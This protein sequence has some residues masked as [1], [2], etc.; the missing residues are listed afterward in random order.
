MNDNEWTNEQ[1]A[2]CE[3]KIDEAEEILDALTR[4]QQA[5]EKNGTFYE[6]TK[7]LLKLYR[8]FRFDAVNEKML[9][10]AESIGKTGQEASSVAE[11]ETIL[12]MPEVYN[13]YSKELLRFTQSNAPTSMALF[14]HLVDAGIRILEHQNSVGQGENYARILKAVYVDAEKETDELFKEL[15]MRRTTFY[16][17]KDE[18]I[19]ALSIVI[20]GPLGFRHPS[21]QFE[22]EAFQAKY[23]WALGIADYLDEYC[24]LI[25]VYNSHQEEE[26]S[27]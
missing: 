14:V 8:P 25:D 11:L 1:K 17:K 19:T 20:F 12:A 21:M 22:D 4:Y 15:N 5:H 13:Y 26:E 18:A 7:M 24:E 10:T 27:A 23:G 9:R 3:A 2:L 16:R 6:A